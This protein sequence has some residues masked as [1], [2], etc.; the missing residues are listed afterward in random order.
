MSHIASFSGVLKVKYFA[1]YGN[2]YT[3]VLLKRI[4]ENYPPPPLW[5]RSVNQAFSKDVQSLKFK[6]F[7]L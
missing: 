1:V 7:I 3:F 2:F 6:N 5:Q 4:V